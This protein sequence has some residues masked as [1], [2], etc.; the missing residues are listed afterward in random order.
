[1]T[2]PPA[3]LSAVA[4]VLPS[5][6]GLRIPA[7]VTSVPSST[8]SVMAASAEIIDHASRM[9]SCGDCGP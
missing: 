8:F 5:W 4:M 3:M 9:G 2:R 1:M 6:A 7:G